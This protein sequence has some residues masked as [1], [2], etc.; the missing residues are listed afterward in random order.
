MFNSAGPFLLNFN[1]KDTTYLASIVDDRE[2]SF[3]AELWDLELLMF[4]VLL[5][6]FFYK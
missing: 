3:R 1:I 4:T 5:D 6:N 2:M